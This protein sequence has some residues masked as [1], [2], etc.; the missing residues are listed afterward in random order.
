MRWLIVTSR[1]PFPLT[2]WTHLRVYHLA[3]AIAFAGQHVTIVS[4]PP[5]ASAG[6]VYAAIGVEVM[7]ARGSSLDGGKGRTLLSPYVF[8]PA[9]AEAVASAAG[10]TDVVLLSGPATLQYA[11][12]A[13]AARCVLAD[14]VDDPLPEYTRSDELGRW[15]D[16]LRLQR[17]RARYERAFLR[18]VDAVICVAPAAAEGVF[19]RHPNVRCETIPNG[20]DAAYF[21]PPVVAAPHDGPRRVVFTGHTS[22]ASNAATAIHLVREIIPRLN[23][24][25]QLQIVGADPTEE[26]LALRAEGAEVTGSVLDVRPYLWN[27]DCVAM[28][29][30]SGAGIKNQ[31]LEAWAA[32]AAVVASTFAV[33]GVPYAANG[34]NVLVADEPGAFAEAVGT[35]L[36]NPARAALLGEAGR[37]TVLEHYA[38]E[39]MGKKLVLLAEGDW[40]G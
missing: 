40:T 4:F 27:A 15:I 36:E 31:L 3:R 35:V 17:G 2:H 7:P 34:E 33:D 29:M 9:L 6:D 32:K 8:Q 19:A 24:P 39:Q 20:V 14:I 18:D 11:R 23:R 38:W 1:F 30:V 13:G 37:R 12:E 22:N 21:E 25:V 10:S 16:R 5:P 26:V 28:P